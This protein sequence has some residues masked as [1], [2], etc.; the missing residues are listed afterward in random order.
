MIQ[1]IV[2][3]YMQKLQQPDQ[4]VFLDKNPHTQLINF[5]IHYNFV[6]PVVIKTNVHHI[7]LR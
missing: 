7:E 3:Q 1:R 2:L 4:A 5:N 6:L